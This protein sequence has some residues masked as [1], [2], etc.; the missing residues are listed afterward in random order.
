VPAPGEAAGA[1]QAAKKAARA[2]QRSVERARS[3]VGG[4]DASGS[5]G[6]QGGV[7]AGKPAAP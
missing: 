6:V 1:R 4:V 7:N 2:T 3:G 5:V